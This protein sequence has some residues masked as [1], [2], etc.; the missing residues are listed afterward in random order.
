MLSNVLPY[1]DIFQASALVS[2]R[3]EPTW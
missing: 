2:K 1:S 3:T